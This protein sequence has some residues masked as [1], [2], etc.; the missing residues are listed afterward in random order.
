MALT[1]CFWVKMG[2]KL[3]KCLKCFINAYVE[4]SDML[5]NCALGVAEKPTEG[6]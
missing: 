5:Y 4:K 1:N 6:E 2:K 3:R